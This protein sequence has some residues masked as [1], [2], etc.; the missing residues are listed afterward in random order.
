MSTAEQ[1]ITEKQFD[2][3]ATLLRLVPTSTAYSIARAVHVD[4]LSIGDAARALGT[5]Y[6]AAH[7]AVNRV[8]AGMELA[9]VAVK[10]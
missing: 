2:A 5:T 1:T 8:N 10:G 6:N 4:G 3:I 7:Q 9:K